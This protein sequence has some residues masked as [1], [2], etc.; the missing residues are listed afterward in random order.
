MAKKD[1]EISD[2][3][4]KL[5][6]ALLLLT[7]LA[8]G[9]IAVAGFVWYEFQNVKSQMINQ[10]GEVEKTA[11]AIPP[12]IYVPMEVFTLTLKPSSQ[13]GPSRVLHIGLT[14]KLADEES[15]EHL[16]KF[17]P[18]IRSRLLILFSQQMAEQLT[19]DNGKHGLIEKI[20]DVVNKPIAGEARVHVT[21]VLFNAFILR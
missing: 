17:L 12:P 5:P 3:K 2:G 14:L 6:F 21:D 11:V 8:L 9:A 4:K 20:K 18:E 1:N 13:G 19:H 10:T 16:E 7:G 15:R